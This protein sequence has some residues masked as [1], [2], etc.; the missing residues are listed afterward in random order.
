MNNKQINLFNLAVEKGVS[1][2]NITDYQNK[3]SELVGKCTKN[4]TVKGTVE[5]LLKTNFECLECE[6]ENQ[7]N[8]SDN[9][10]YFLSL[11]AA[12]YTTGMSIFNREGQLLGHKALNVSKQKD[13]YERLYDIKE[14]IH[15]IIKKNDIK[16][17][18]LEDIQYQQ[19]PALFKKL[20]MLQGIL[21]YMIIV[22]LNLYLITAM[23]DEWRS[24]NHIYG[25]KRKEQK[26]A[27]I[28]RAKEIFKK[29]IGEDESESI[30]LGLYGIY[31][32]NK[33]IKEE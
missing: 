25:S 4:H 19:N 6:S 3:D 2:T 21:R 24:Y 26:E 7:L 32:Y 8:I 5:Y 12:T 15:K 16:C 23:A 9:T 14:E 13:F 20:A 29:D 22:D 10:P 18:I 27:A 28:K 33:D 1:I 31:Q 30:F 17:I 11:D